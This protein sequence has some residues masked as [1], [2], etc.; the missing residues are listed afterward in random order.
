M[1]TRCSASC[2]A[3]A[4]RPQMAQRIGRASARP[5]GPT[6]PQTPGSRA[7]SQAVRN[8]RREAALE[9]ESALDRV[10][11]EEE[12]VSEAAALPA[13]GAG[14][15]VAGRAQAATRVAETRH[16]STPDRTPVRRCGS[17]RLTSGPP[18]TARRCD[19]GST[20]RPKPPLEASLPKAEPDR[21]TIRPGG[22][23]PRGES[24]RTSV[25]C[26]PLTGGTGYSTTSRPERNS[27]SDSAIASLPTV[28]RAPLAT[29]SVDRVSAT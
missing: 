14:V 5:Q 23:R 28:S 13:V 24:S 10:R 25:S 19:W 18:P 17:R 8:A 15:C 9:G 4:V 21:C 3:P 20:T 27:G 12:A 6:G 11:G 22:R 1:N 26:H 16:A 2:C 7:I 29:S